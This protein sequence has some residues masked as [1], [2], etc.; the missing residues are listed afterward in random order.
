MGKCNGHPSPCLGRSI[1][2]S[3]QTWIE[4]SHKSNKFWFDPIQVDNGRGGLKECIDFGK[5]GFTTIWFIFSRQIFSCDRSRKKN[6]QELKSWI[7]T[8]NYLF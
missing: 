2:W 7:L 6:Y 1:S 5:V 8:V 4:N 3:L